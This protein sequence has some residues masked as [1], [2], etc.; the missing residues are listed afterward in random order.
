MYTEKVKKSFPYFISSTGNSIQEPSVPSLAR[1]SL[2]RTQNRRL[3]EF[4][5]SSPHTLSAITLYYQ[6]HKLLKILLIT[7]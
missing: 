2:K 5:G 4:T 6:F 3:Q 7:S 1:P